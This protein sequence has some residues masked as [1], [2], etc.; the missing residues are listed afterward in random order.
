MFW[1][2]YSYDVATLL[3]LG[4]PNFAPL[5][6]VWR[7]E[8]LLR[9]PEGI[10]PRSLRLSHVGAQFV[11][12]AIWYD[13]YD[14]VDK[15]IPA[16][17]YC[18]RLPVWGTDSKPF[19]RQIARLRKFGEWVEPLVLAELGL[20]CTLRSG[21]PDPLGGG[22]ARCLE[23]ADGGNRITVNRRQGMISVSSVKSDA[24]YYNI[25]LAS[26]RKF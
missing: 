1:H 13:K 17:V 16:G 25:S 22:E 5:P 10:S 15:E 26:Y 11:E 2:G 20:L 9:V 4:R 12:Q 19:D 14:W 7:H 3:G 6:K 23:E 21:H 18:L 24:G 8:M